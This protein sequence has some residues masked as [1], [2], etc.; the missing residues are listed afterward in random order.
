MAPTDRT[1][2]PAYNVLANGLRAIIGP[3][4]GSPF[5]TEYRAAGGGYEGLQAIASRAL[6]IA[7]EW[8]EQGK[9][10]PV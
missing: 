5:A 9:T 3:G 8:D 7:T 6:Q 2:D 1:N 10:G 4:D